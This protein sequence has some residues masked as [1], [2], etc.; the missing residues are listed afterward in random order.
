MWT[1][2]K[3]VRKG[4]SDG[5]DDGKRDKGMEYERGGHGKQY[6]FKR[7]PTRLDL[8]S[9]LCLIRLQRQ[10][11]LWM[12]KN[13]LWP[14]SLF[15]ARSPCFSASQAL[16]RFF[17]RQYKPAIEYECHSRGFFS[18]SNLSTTQISSSP[19]HFRHTCSTNT[20]L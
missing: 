10:E 16:L 4:R 15:I 6:V 14:I 18:P 2:A 17:F 9:V 12:S 20:T 5:G 11:S 13:G 19:T 8:R 7:K 3:A 1:M